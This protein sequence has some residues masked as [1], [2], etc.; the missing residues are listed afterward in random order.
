MKAVLSVFLLSLLTACT[1]TAPV[2]AIKPDDSLATT[3]RRNKMIGTW[4]GDTV[5]K[6][7]G[8]KM[9]IVQRHPDG[10]QRIDFKLIGADGTVTEQSEIGVWGI[11]GPI[12]FVAIRGFIEGQQV[13]PADTSSPYL[14]DAYEILELTPQVFRYRHMDNDNEYMISRVE[15]GFSFPE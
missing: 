14:Y 11:S 10:T 3:E 13:Y 15:D 12:Y 8:R 9:H 4:F 7:G 6:D 5:T 2:D 1:S